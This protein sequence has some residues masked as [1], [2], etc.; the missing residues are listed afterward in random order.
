MR[1]FIITIFL[2]VLAA[3]FSFS[4]TLTIRVQAPSDTPD[5]A[6]LFVAG[7]LPALG[8]W[9]ADG[10][11]MMKGDS[12]IWSGSVTAPKGTEIEFK[13]TLGNWEQEALYAAGDIPGNVRVVLNADTTV[14]L[15]PAT[16][17]HLG[18]KPSGGITGTVRYH[19]GVMARGLTYARRITVWLPP[20][21][22]SAP[23]R[24]Y[25]V[26]YMHDGQNIFD[27]RT[28]FGGND[29]QVDEVADSLIRHGAMEEII[30][31]GITNSPDRMLE[32]SDTTLGRAYAS[33]VVDQLKPMID[34]TYRTKPDR[35]NTATMGSSMGGLISFLFVWWHP[36]VF[37]K[38]ACLSSAFRW[39]DNKMIR[40][41]EKA[42]KLPRDIAVYLD[43]G[44]AG[45]EARLQ[46]GYERMH[47]L[48]RKKGLIEGKTVMGFL[49]AGAEH[50]ERAWA[51]RLWRP[52]KFLFPKSA[53]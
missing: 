1:P 15:S 24:R 23:T 36:E 4:Q 35:A 17:K 9:Q 43:C 13:V 27:P 53:E 26:L 14:H 34:S 3:A 51:R 19:R 45:I 46:P 28:S 42:K 7:N 32:Y 25:P 52:L 6:T 50:T 30:V 33:F 29:W 21:Y 49:D 47:K 31:V 37:S 22:D 39:A 12:A 41:V 5:T 10:L 11:R 2:I 20:S 38:A 44:T 40:Q 16:W 18:Y 8:Q 48:L